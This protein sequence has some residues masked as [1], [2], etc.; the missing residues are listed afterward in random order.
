MKTKYPVEVAS[1]IRKNKTFAINSYLVKANGLDNES[2]YKVYGKFSRFALTIMDSSSVKNETVTANIRV[3][4]FAIIRQKSC[5]ALEHGMFHEKNQATESASPAY[6]EIIGMGT[7]KG[8]SPA[9]VILE[10]NGKELIKQRQFLMNN[11]E[12]YPGNKKMLYAIDQA[13]TLY[14]Q[15]NLAP[16]H[17][18]AVASDHT[19]EIY[20]AG[21][22]PLIRKR[23]DDGK[24]FVYDMSISWSFESD[25]PV[26]VSILNYYA[27]VIK[28]NDGR[29]NVR[30]IDLH[31]KLN[32]AISMTDSEWMNILESIDKNMRMF[33]FL[34]ARSIFTEAYGI[35][36]EI[37]RNAKA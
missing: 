21:M 6:T 11:L 37:I 25:Y 24:C 9:Q 10:G 4:D 36:S 18:T 23:R 12:K 31:S 28:L 19:V 1:V 14:K 34:N 32:L 29:L 13:I 30:N 16:T 20:R 27:D 3:S 26:T 35:Y 17:K 15:N 33:E 22:H 7:L 2:P 5:I 8:K